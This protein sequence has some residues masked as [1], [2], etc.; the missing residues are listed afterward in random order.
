M[1]KVKTR[2]TV[3]LADEL[4]NRKIIFGS[5]AALKKLKSGEVERIYLSNDCPENI[6]NDL[7]NK[8]EI[9]NLPMTKEE[10]KNLCKKTFNISAFSVLKEK[11]PIALAKEEEKAEKEKKP[12]KEKEKKPRKKK[13]K[14]EDKKDANL[15]LQ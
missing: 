8:V 3:S 10:L 13:I 9:I 6:L 4:K 1:K 14:K 2:T 7:K 11:T 5:R 15:P 12:I